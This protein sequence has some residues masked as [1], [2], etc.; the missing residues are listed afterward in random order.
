MWHPSQGSAI[1]LSPPADE[2]QGNPKPPRHPPYM[3]AS[4]GITRL[5]GPAIA[6]YLLGKAETMPVKSQISSLRLVYP[7]VSNQEAYWLQTDA[8]VEMILRRSDFYMVVGRAEARFE[9][10]AVDESSGDVALTFAIAGGLSDSGVLKIRDLPGAGEAPQLVLEGG[11]KL[12]RVWD[13]PREE[14]GAQILEWFT[15]EKLLFDRS[16]ARPGIIGFDRHRELS[17]YDLFYVGIATKGD[18]FDRLVKNGHKKRMEVLANEPQRHPSSRVSDETYLLFFEI[19]TLGIQTFD[20][21][22]DFEEVGVDFTE[23]RKRIVADAEKAFVKL[24]DP[25]YNDQKYPKYPKGSDG[26]YGTGLTRYGYV[27][28]ENITLNTSRNVIKGAHDP[29]HGMSNDADSIFVD[30]EEVRLCVAGVDY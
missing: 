4:V 28:D 6:P 19:E 25:R 23:D 15:T 12:F 2:A 29:V 22:D 8:E 10:T 14:E 13:R 1:S 9:I 18:S 16:H 21:D 27:I 17:T 11:E 7:P 5:G 30:G 24:L 20:V 26:L 3:A